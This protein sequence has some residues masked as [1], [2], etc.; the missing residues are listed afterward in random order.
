MILP[1]VNLLIYAYN[2]AVPFHR[3][4]KHW[5]EEVMNSR[6]PVALPWAVSCGFI[7]IMTHPS[8]L[9]IPMS[10]EQAVDIV[11]SWVRR[12]NVDIIDPGSR[13]LEILRDLLARLGTAGRLTT[14]AHLAAIAIEYQCE[15]FSNDTD[16]GRFPGLRWINPLR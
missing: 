2:T 10:P 8:I 9:E 7:R 1:D 6:K 5:W 11:A 15:L 16:F 12:S 13:H 4:A 14:D 3:E